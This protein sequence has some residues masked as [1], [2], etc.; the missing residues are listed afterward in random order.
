MSDLNIMTNGAD[1]RSGIKFVKRSLNNINFRF[2]AAGFKPMPI[3]FQ[4]TRITPLGETALL[5][6]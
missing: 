3:G 2:P 6:R 4:N 5:T 1:C